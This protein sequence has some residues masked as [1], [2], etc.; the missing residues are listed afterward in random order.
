M[1][2]T[3]KVLSLILSLIL[4]FSMCTIAFAD[5]QTKT[6]AL[7][8]EISKSGKFYARVTGHTYDLVTHPMNFDIFDDFNKGVIGVNLP[9]KGIK[10]VYDNGTV[11]ATFFSLFYVTAS[12]ENFPILSAVSAPVESFQKIIKSFVDDPNLEN[13]NCTITTV[14]KNGETCICERYTGKILTVSGAFIYNSKGE[15]CEIQLADTLGEYI[16]Y[17]VTDVKA[18]FPDSSMTKGLFDFSFIWGLLKLLLSAA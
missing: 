17:D 5:T 16:G 10:A 9:N 12:P 11:T 8:N 6:A 7:L 4:A 14:E 3:N 18:D 13:F 15:L 1:K 2:T